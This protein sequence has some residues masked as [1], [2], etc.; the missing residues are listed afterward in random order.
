MSCHR[1]QIVPAYLMVLLW[2]AAPTLANP[3]PVRVVLLGDSYISS[4]NVDPKRAFAVQLEAALNAEEP[5]A[6]IISTDYTATTSRGVARLKSFL[7]TDS[8]LGGSGPKVVILELGS[9]DCFRYKLEET[10]ANLDAILKVF[11]NLHIPVLVAGTT[12]YTTC[13]RRGQPD[14]SARYVQMFAALA[15]KYGD[16]YY[17]E[18]KEGVGDHSELMQ[19]DRDHPTAEGDAV[20]VARILPLVRELV[21]RAQR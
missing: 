21:V 19:G 18:F 10:E 7:E 9:N 4:H 17:R 3:V 8:I 6:Q 14:Y 5:L 11:A 15:Q 1:P 16:L 12:P 20:I 13:E 2:L